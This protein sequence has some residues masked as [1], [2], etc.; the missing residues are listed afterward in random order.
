MVFAKSSPNFLYA[1]IQSRLFWIV[2]LRQTKCLHW[3]QVSAAAGL[4][5][6]AASASAVQESTAK[7]L[8]L[9]TPP[10]GASEAS[11]LRLGRADAYCRDNGISPPRSANFQPC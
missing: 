7:T 4:G 11:S 5:S 8:P 3:S 6:T 1:A 9:M 2:A 10:L